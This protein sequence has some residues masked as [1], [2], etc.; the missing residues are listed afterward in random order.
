MLYHEGWGVESI[1]HSLTYS[2]G[3]SR[4]YMRT[5]ATMDMLGFKGFSPYTLPNVIEISEGIPYIDMTN[6]DHQKLYDLKGKIVSHG[7]KAITGMEMPVF[8]KRRFQHGAASPR[9]F[10]RLFPVKEMAYRKE[11]LSIYE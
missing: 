5:F 9:D 10:N 11:F 1:K 2:G 3:L 7:I 8:P 4:G 6:W